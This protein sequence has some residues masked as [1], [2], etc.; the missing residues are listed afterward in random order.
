MPKTNNNHVTKS[1]YSP[2]ARD[3]DKCVEFNPLDRGVPA[4]VAR[5]PIVHLRTLTQFY[6]LHPVGHKLLDSTSGTGSQPTCHQPESYDDRDESDGSQSDSGSDSILSI[7]S[8]EVAEMDDSE[9][10][11]EEEPSQADSKKEG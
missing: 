6:C 5:I 8:T 3:T 11:I 1:R 2:Y 10:A 9:E 4:P 7:S